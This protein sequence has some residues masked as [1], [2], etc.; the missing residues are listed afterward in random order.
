MCNLTPYSFLQCNI[1]L[2]V[3][4]EKFKYLLLYHVCSVIGGNIH[5]PAHAFGR[6]SLLIHVT[7]W[8][9]GDGDE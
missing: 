8:M 6:D 2:R 3:T 1:F 9:V 5:V 7:N 4:E